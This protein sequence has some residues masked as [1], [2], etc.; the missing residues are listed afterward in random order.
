[1]QAANNISTSPAFA[2]QYAKI[3]KHYAVS[4]KCPPFIFI[5]ASNLSLCLIYHQNLAG[6]AAVNIAVRAPSGS[7]DSCV[8]SQLFV[9]V[10]HTCTLVQ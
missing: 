1:M 7:M 3:L 9:Y 5:Y 10:K 2:F 4:T 6:I 8:L